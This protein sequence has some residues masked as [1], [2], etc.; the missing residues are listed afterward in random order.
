MCLKPSQDLYLASCQLPILQVGLGSC[1]LCRLGGLWPCV[2][3]IVTIIRRRI[4][5][6]KCAIHMQP[7]RCVYMSCP[8]HVCRAEMK[9]TPLTGS[10]HH[11]LEICILRLSGQCIYWILHNKAIQT[12]LH[13]A[14]HTHE[15]PW[16]LA[17]DW[18]RDNAQNNFSSH[19]LCP[20]NS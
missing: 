16:D 15:V 19:A 3:W 2:M 5:R 1:V 8:T 7:P 13:C 14:L 18:R 4:R 10:A 6:L 20:L 17:R 9:C 11:W 12:K